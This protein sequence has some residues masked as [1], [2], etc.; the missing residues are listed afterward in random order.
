[1]TG[2]LRA[3]MIIV[4]LLL[5]WWA[6]VR[7]ANAQ[8]ADCISVPASAER[9]SLDVA[10]DV[11]SVPASRHGTQ[12]AAFLGLNNVSAN[13]TT[14]V[15]QPPRPVQDVLRGAPDAEMLKLQP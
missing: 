11:P 13:G 9:L 7:V 6:L 8:P 5:G 15:T 12:G 10:V 4:A 1:M 14:C 2:I 3:G